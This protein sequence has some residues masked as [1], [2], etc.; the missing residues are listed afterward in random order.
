MRK[1]KGETG[2]GFH[3]FWMDVPKTG[4]VEVGRRR[5]GW[6]FLAASSVRLVRW[7][8][9]ALGLTNQPQDD[10]LTGG[11][12]Q[13]GQL[14]F[15]TCVSGGSNSGCGVGE[16]GCENKRRVACCGIVGWGS[17]GGASTEAGRNFKSVGRWSG[18][19]SERFVNIGY[20]PSLVIGVT[21]CDLLQG[22]L[23]LQNSEM[24]QI[25]FLQIPREIIF[26]CC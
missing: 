7:F 3:V 12:R 16:H 25:F 23:Q 18:S 9:P 19:A 22:H 13:T 2:K 24:K 5:G 8:L 21:M 1:N 26:Q 20:E 14:A 6:I 11:I 17:Q 10:Q 15:S 4:Y